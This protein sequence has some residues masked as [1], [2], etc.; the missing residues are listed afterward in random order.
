M[1][2][3]LEGG[4]G[5]TEY[6]DTE[7]FLRGTRGLLRFYGSVLQYCDLQ[8]AWAF[9]ASFANS[10]PANVMTGTALVAFLETAGHALNCRFG[11]Q[12][13]KLLDALAREW[14]P[15]LAKDRQGEA[16]AARLRAYC[17][18]GFPDAPEGMHLQHHV[19]DV[20]V[21]LEQRGIQTRRGG[22][23]GRGPGYGR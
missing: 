22:Y 17:Q 3:T 20:E 19:E 9:V 2:R 1:C 18:M 16:P 5:S 7:T 13:Q 15:A 8:R 12:F 10:V 21:V 11:R 6:E 14:L 23:G 4:S